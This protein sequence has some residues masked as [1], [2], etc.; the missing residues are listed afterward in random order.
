MPDQ[1]D[2]ASVLAHVTRRPIAHRG[3]H[4]GNGSVAEN[5]ASAF[6]AAIDAGYAIECDVHIAADGVPVVFHDNDL[7][8]L[9]GVD[10]L[11][12]GKTS[13]ELANLKLAGTDDRIDTLANL[14]A[15]TRGRVPLVVE[16]KGTDQKADGAFVSNLA[17]VLAGYDGPLAL[18]SF[19]RWLIEQAL[20]A[21]LPFPVGLVAESLRPECLEQHMAVLNLG[22]S[23]VSYNVHHLPN[24]FIEHVRQ[25]RHLPVICWTV[26]NQEEADRSRPF[27]D[28]ITFEGFTPHS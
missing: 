17:P 7:Q 15:M 1:S 9:T 19:D 4:D 2:I 14:L 18:M 3:L 21:E 16:I 20:A 28:Q 13:L 27:A 11:V 23:F 25:D 12:S 10:A 8:R 26:R 24:M 5:S 6:R 22:C